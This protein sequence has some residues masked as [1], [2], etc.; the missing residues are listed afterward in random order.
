MQD[1]DT[2]A[3][4]E[5]AKYKATLPS[6]WSIGTQFEIENKLRV[7]INYSGSQWSDYVNPAKL[8]T[9]NNAFNFSVGVEYTPNYISY[10]NYLE[11]IRYRLSYNHGKNLES[12]KENP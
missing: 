11:K 2:I 9:L 5:N 1:K 6:E 8:D 10:N 7:G 4:R 12:S 3:I